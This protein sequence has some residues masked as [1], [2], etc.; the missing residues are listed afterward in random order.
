[1]IVFSMNVSLHQKFLDLILIFM[2]LNLMQIIKV[3][4]FHSFFIATAS[5]YLTDMN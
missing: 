5:M 1:M 3:F 4:Y 2:I